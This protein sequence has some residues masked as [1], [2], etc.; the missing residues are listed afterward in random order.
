MDRPHRS[1]RDT[2]GL[3]RLRDL[4]AARLRRQDPESGQAT[5]EFALLLFP[6]LIVVGGII[7]FGI[8]L[9]MWLDRTVLRTK[10]PVRLLST[11]G[12][13]SASATD[14]VQQLNHQLAVQ[15]R[16]KDIDPLQHQGKA[17]GRASMPGRRR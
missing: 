15:L 5:V 11:T 3:V 10:E 13:R 6:L 8:G 14:H 16:Q 2:R 9:N 1:D 4:T 17:A 12:L 7:Y